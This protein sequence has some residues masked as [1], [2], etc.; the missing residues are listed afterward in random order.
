MARIR[1]G[2]GWKTLLGALALAL[3][4]AAGVMF[5]P[6]NSVSAAPQQQCSGDQKIEGSSAFFTAPDGKSIQRICIKA[7]T[8]TFS[9][10]CGET[11]S[12][13]NIHWIYAPDCYYAIAVEV[14][15]GGTSRYCKDISNVVATFIDCGQNPV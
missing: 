2:M 6:A 5:M 14:T 10:A 12:C 9:F 11:S 3:V 15:G 8:E 7:G 13:Y 1:S 4:V